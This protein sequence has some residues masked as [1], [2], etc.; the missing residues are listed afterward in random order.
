MLA[1]DRERYIALVSGTIAFRLLKPLARAVRVLWH[2]AVEGLLAGEERNHF[3]VHQVR[4]LALQ[5]HVRHLQQH[6]G[7]RTDRGEVP[8]DV[9]ELAAMHH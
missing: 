1:L 5:L 9:V 6:G 4:G 7:R 3:S 2:E 8:V